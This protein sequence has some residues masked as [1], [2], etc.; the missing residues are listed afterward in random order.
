MLV[1]RPDRRVVPAV[2]EQ[3]H[4]SLLVLSRTRAILRGRRARGNEAARCPCGKQAP[5]R[6]R[7]TT[8]AASRRCALARPTPARTPPAGAVAP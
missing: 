4:W 3:S 5:R 1:A 8:G 2:P 6:A 7:V